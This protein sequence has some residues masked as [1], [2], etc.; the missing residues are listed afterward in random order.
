MAINEI[1]CSTP[2]INYPLHIGTLTGP[3]LLSFMKNIAEK[4]NIST[5]SK[6]LL[7]CHSPEFNTTDVSATLESFVH[8]RM[9]E[10][11]SLGLDTNLS[12]QRDDL[13]KDQMTETINQLITKEYFYVSSGNLYFNINKAKQDFKEGLDTI[14]FYPSRFKNQFENYLNVIEDDRI[15]NRDL[16]YGLEVPSL[17]ITSPISQVQEQILFAAKNNAE[18][19]IVTGRNVLGHYAF[20]AAL[21]HYVMHTTPMHVLVHSTFKKPVDEHFIPNNNKIITYD[22]LLGIHEDTSQ[23]YFAS[24]L[25]LLSS[26]TDADQMVLSNTELQK[27]KKIYSKWSNLQKFAQQKDQS[28][29][30]LINS[31]G[32]KFSRRSSIE[33]FLTRY[34]SNF[35]DKL[36]FET[37]LLSRLV[38]ENL[39]KK[40]KNMLFQNKDFSPLETHT[41]LES[42]LIK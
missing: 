24:D 9:D 28:V 23:S 22:D 32:V 5:T 31:F 8:D 7:N 34:S 13:I 26:V 17:Q 20:Q 33:S 38:S 41:I 2:A 27:V 18:K 37:L 15:L 16:Q 4:N 21:L 10:Y 36:S 1:Y 3:K 39:N 35:L 42:V 30:K 19:L 6:I 29:L 11:N 12:F 25:F 40:T 14:H